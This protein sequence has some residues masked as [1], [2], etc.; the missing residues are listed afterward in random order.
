MQ[1]CPVDVPWHVSTYRITVLDVS[2]FMFDNDPN[3]MNG[4]RKPS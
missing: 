4:T 1:T 3:R 2:F